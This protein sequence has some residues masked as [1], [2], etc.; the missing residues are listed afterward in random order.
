MITLWSGRYNNALVL[1][2]QLA[3]RSEAVLGPDHRLVLAPKF[4]KAYCT[5]K[6]GKIDE[7]L[8]MLDAAA[9]ETARV[10]GQFDT[11]TLHRQIIIARSPD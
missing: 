2:E 8:A 11:A 5:F 9:S 10:L 3:A 4:S 1:A 6:L 7:G